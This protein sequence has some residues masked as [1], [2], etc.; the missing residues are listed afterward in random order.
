[1]N[2]DRLKEM[3]VALNMWGADLLA[4]RVCV[5]QMLVDHLRRQEPEALRTFSNNVNELLATINPKAGT[6][7]AF[8]H[9]LAHER[10]SKLIDTVQSL[11]RLL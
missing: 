7:G 9:T 4:V 2:D 5:V 10:L 8:V 3:N 6:E 11:M 1:M